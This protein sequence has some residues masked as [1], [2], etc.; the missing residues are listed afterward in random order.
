MLFLS[1]CL[2]LAC[3]EQQLLEILPIVIF[4]TNKIHVPNT[5]LKLLTV[6]L[7]YYILAYSCRS[8]CEIILCISQ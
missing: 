1:F 8:I 7:S 6:K 4:I 2:D 5:L 3:E